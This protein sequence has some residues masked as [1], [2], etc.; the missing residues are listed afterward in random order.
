M[1]GGIDELD[2]SPIRSLDDQWQEPL[3]KLAHDIIL[4]GVIQGRLLHE[5]ESV[6]Q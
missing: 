5:L 6:M 4:R 1:L 3:V 2:L